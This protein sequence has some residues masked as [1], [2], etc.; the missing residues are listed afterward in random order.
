[1][2]LWVIL[3]L[4]KDINVTTLH[5]KI[6]VDVIFKEQESYFTNPNL[7]GENSTM[8]DKDMGASYFI[9]HLYPSLTHYHHRIPPY[10]SPCW[11]CVYTRTRT[12]KFSTKDR[13]A[14]LKKERFGK[15][16]WRKKMIVPDAK[17]V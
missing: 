15:K 3:R 11:N 12:R 10:P 17:H 7:H 4:E 13:L 9:C 16:F 6:F 1:M 14:P 8:E 5:P 2:S